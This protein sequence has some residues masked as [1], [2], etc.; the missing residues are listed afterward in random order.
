MDEPRPGFVIQHYPRG[1]LA[2]L[3]LRGF[4]LPA[5]SWTASLDR[6]LRFD[7]R[8]EAVALQMR[9]CGITASIIHTSEIAEA[10]A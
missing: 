8:D 5:G 10:S 3:Y 9:L 2:P 6:A 1:A 7:L 4:N